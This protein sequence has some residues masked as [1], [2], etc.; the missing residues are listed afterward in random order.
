M[1]ADSGSSL[2]QAQVHEQVRQD[3]RDSD[4]EELQ[5]TLNRDLIR[6]IIDLNF[7][8]R[9]RPQDYPR[10]DIYEEDEQDLLQLAE[11]ITPFIDRGLPVEVSVILDK[12]GLEMPDEGADLLG[13][14][15]AP[16]APGEDEEEDGEGDE[17]KDAPEDEEKNIR[18]AGVI[19]RIASAAERTT[20]MRH[21]KKTLGELLRDV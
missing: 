19:R 11:A 20:N 13:A 17:D 12:F 8:P 7:G 9:P 6:P 3:I 15:A 18:L 10:V 16:S 2:S 1:T 4:I 5:D 14:M 21:F